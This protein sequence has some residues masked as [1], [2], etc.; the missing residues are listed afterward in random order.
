M[1]FY[2]FAYFSFFL[3]FYVCHLGFY[4]YEAWG[5]EEEVGFDSSFFLFFDLYLSMFAHLFFFFSFSLCM[6]MLLLV[7]VMLAIFLVAIRID[8]EV[9]L[10]SIV[11]H[12]D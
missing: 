4:T 11:A 5:R 7:N 10:I 1:S 2:L 6:P 8:R 9:T 3:S 12:K